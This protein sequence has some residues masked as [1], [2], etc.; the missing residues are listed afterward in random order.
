MKARSAAARLS[1][2]RPRPTPP[3]DDPAPSEDLPAWGD[4]PEGDHALDHVSF[5]VQVAAWWSLC[6]MLVVGGL[7]TIV[8][9][10]SR[11]GLVTVTITIA[12]MICALLQPMVAL[13]QR[14]GL[15][16]PPA[17]LIVFIGGIGVIGYL[18]WFVISQIAYAKDSLTGQLQGAADEIRNWLINGP[19]RMTPKQADRFSVDLVQTLSEH[20][21]QIITGAF[22][23]ATSAIGILSGVILCVFATLFLM[24]DNGSI[25]RWFVRFLPRPTHAHAME[26]GQVAWR[27]LTAYTR[28]LVLL[29][30]IN[31]LAMVPAMMIAG[32]PLVVPLAV[33]LFLGSLVP[34]VG[35]LIAGAVVCLV[36]FITQGL[37]T[38]IVLA[39]VLV[40]VVQLFGNLLNP[41]ILGKAVDIHPLAILVCVTAG[42]ILAGAFGAFVAVPLAAVVNNAIRAVR[43]HQ[44]ART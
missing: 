27:T 23:A 42:T 30:A 43:S 44:Q 1:G 14:V 7:W 35:V 12:V 29:A 9:L 3:P 2:L 21:H 16:R 19:L 17:V 33:L 26:A 24:L 10:L 31:A 20:Q 38:A 8:V 25:W 18:S 37:T 13:L 4:R 5:G 22:Q 15:P 39:I 40:V 34:L 32:L 36:A 41:I 6:L 28:S 11:I